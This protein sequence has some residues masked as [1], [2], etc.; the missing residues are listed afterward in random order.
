MAKGRGRGFESRLPGP[1]SSL[2]T[3]KNKVSPQ[4]TSKKLP[5]R[6]WL[7]GSEAGHSRKV[8]IRSNIYFLY[9]LQVT[10]L[11]LQG[12]MKARR[13]RTRFRLRSPSQLYTRPRSKCSRSRLPNPNLHHCPHRPLLRPLATESSAASAT[14]QSSRL[15]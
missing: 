9:P 7:G 12:A 13:N 14:R 5:M 6:R 4:R 1:R 10:F 2:S 3:I 8:N 11:F 15:G